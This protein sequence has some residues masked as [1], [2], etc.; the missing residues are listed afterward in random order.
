[1]THPEQQRQMA[2]EIEEDC[3][4]PGVI[5]FI[6]GS[7]IQLSSALQGKGTITIEKDSLYTITGTTKFNF[8]HA[9]VRC[10]SSICEKSES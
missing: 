7:H 6:D 5:G 10:M 2:E 9:K 3:R 1:M 8:V 4:L